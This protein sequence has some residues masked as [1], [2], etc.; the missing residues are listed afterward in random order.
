MPVISPDLAAQRKERQNQIIELE[1]EVGFS[2]PKQESRQ[3]EWEEE[4]LEADRRWTVLTPLRFIS[5]SGATLQ[6]QPDNSLLVSGIG[7]WDDT[8]S[9]IAR[10]EL[11]NI[12]AVRLELLADDRLPGR[13]PGRVTGG[14]VVLSEFELSVAPSAPIA[15]FKPAPLTNA[16][17]DFAQ[18][19]FPIGAA[20]DG[21]LAAGWAIAPAVGQPH[22][23][24]F[25]LQ[26]P[27]SL[28]EGALLRFSL[29]QAFGS[30]V[31]IGKSWLRSAMDDERGRFRILAAFEYA[32]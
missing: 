4:W 16:T 10:T 6:R 5:A 12:T 27:V 1:N 21:D 31:T 19:A 30:Y 22:Q 14:N 9:I 11:T 7:T 24:V 18:V 26:Q 8:Y 17:T 25:E 3:S 20:L 13:G 23:A 32:Q 29:K 28:P 15:I 2:K